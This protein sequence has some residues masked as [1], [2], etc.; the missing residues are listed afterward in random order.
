MKIPI[1]YLQTDIR[2]GGNDY[3]APGEKTTIAKSGCGP[4]CVAMILAT[5]IDYNITPADT[6]WWAKQNGY[7]ACKQGTYYSY[8]KAHLKLYGINAEQVNNTNIYGKSTQTANNAHAKALEAIKSG[9]WVICCMGPGNWTSSGHF[10]LWYGIDKN[11]VLIRDPNSIKQGRIRNKLSLLQQQVK[12]Y[13]IIDIEAEE[14]EDDEMITDRAITIFGKEYT[15]KGILKDGSNYIS[16]KVLKEA[17]F[18]VGN[19]GSE[20]IISMP[21]VKLKVA[22]KNKTLTGFSSNGTNYAGIRELAEALGHK[23]SWD[24]ESRTVVIE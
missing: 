19:Q 7:K 13:W 18:D 24:Q 3:S 21:T 4:T 6:C 10:I 2:W 17:G 22:G 11:D 1:K 23:V 8:I 9:K 14:K 5:L 20:P 12:Y 16:P 15:A